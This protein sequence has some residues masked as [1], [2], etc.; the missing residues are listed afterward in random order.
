MAST[1]ADEV[2][3][4]SRAIVRRDGTLARLRAEN[5]RLRAELAEARE[6]QADLQ[7]IVDI[8]TARMRRAAR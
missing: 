6:R 8:W 3:A 2:D 1:G 5:A 4:L 7:D